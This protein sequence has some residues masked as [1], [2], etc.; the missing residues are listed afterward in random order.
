MAMG[1]ALTLAH[2]R[3]GTGTPLVLVHPLG[4]DRVAWEPVLAPLAAEHDVIAVDMP[5][6]GGSE[7]LAAEVRATPAAIAETIVATLDSLGLGQAHVA[8]IS[9]GG[10]VAL[11][12]G[13]TGRTL[14]VTAFNPAGFWRRPLGPRSEVA[15]STARRL[16]PL[17]RPL[18]A[19]SVGRR[20]ALSGTVAHPERVPAAA[21]SRLVRAYALARGFDRA[22]AEMRRTLFEG[23]GDIPVPVTLAWSD[24]DRLVGRPDED[25]PGARMV[26][27]TDCGHVPTWDAPD[28]VVATILSNTRAVDRARR[29]PPA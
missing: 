21:A 22:N 11:E 16:L 1:R 27:L 12:L 9:L 4:A 20:I 14:S 15:R 28:Q 10:W 13:K 3:S 2:E 7:P 8:G 18:L 29:G 19:T 17:A 23:F 24:R 25:P 6:F 5:G 26:S